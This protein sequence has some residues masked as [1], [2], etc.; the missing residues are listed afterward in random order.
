MPSPGAGS[1]ISPQDARDLLN[2]WMNESTKVQG[3]LVASNG[4]RAQVLGTV[5]PFPNGAVSVV[6][7]RKPPLTTFFEFKPGLAAQLRYGDDRAFPAGLTEEV[8]GAPT[9]SS[10][11]TFTFSD[12]SVVALFEV[13]DWE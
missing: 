8:A 6:L 5:F 7:D 9:L 13:V 11:L 4:F 3:L 2:K 10:T 12:G 1:D